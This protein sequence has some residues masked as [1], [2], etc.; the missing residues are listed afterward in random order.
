MF[1]R[2]M[3]CAD[4]VVPH[5]AQAEVSV[6]ICRPTWCA[7]PDH[8]AT[9]PIEILEGV[10]V[11]RILFDAQALHSFVRVL[12]LTDEPYQV[13]KDQLFGTASKSKYLGQSPSLFKMGRSQSECCEEG[14][15]FQGHPG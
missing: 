13:Q 11:A 1:I 7:G 5:G 10:V 3:L 2:Y 8:W 12:N 6:E 15:P 9:D 14:R 4:C